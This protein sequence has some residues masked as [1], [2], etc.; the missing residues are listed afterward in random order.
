MS[1]N[2]FEAV[3]R[4]FPIITLS[5]K[6]RTRFEEQI[7]IPAANLALRMQLS[8]SSYAVRLQDNPLLDFGP[9]IVGDLRNT[10]F[11]DLETRR[12]LKA[13]A[14]IYLNSNEHIATPIIALEPCLWRNNEGK[15][16]TYLCQEKLLVQLYRPLE[17]RHKASRIDSA[18]STSRYSSNYLLDV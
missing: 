8:P 2:V 4:V 7:A 6:S 13:D 15:G 18:V 14:A 11:L 16:P 9:V 10:R 1:N 17:K 12:L 5:D 3:S